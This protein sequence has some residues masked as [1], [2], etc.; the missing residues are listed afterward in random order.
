[1][2]LRRHVPDLVC[3][4]DVNYLSP[5]LV[6]ERLLTPAECSHMLQLHKHNT[7]EYT[8]V[9]LVNTIEGKGPRAYQR[10]RRA[11]ECSTTDG[12]G[13]L[14]HEDLLL[15]ILAAEDDDNELLR[16]SDSGVGWGNSCESDASEVEADVCP[17]ARPSGMLKRLWMQAGELIERVERELPRVRGRSE[18]LLSVLQQERRERM[19]E[20]EEVLRCLSGFQ[21]YSANAKVRIH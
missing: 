19:Q 6:A 5:Y 7:R 9:S 12:D 2:T 11:L 14:G 13:H 4:L 8:I 17:T 16:S 3:L 21:L 20:K 1:M 18:H 15:R 10:F